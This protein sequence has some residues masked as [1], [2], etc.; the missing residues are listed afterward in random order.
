MSGVEGESVCVIHLFVVEGYN[1]GANAHELHDNSISL[2]YV[3]HTQLCDLDPCFAME[4]WCQTM[5]RIISWWGDYHQT[6]DY[7]DFEYLHRTDWDEYALSL[8]HI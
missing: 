4:I 8:I 7:P 3:G 6:W 5:P 2:N 1:S